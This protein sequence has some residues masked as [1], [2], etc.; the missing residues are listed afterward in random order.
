MNKTLIAA[1]VALS[2]I[3]SAQAAPT[4][5]DF[6]SVTA[7][8]KANGFS[9]PG[10]PG[11]TFTDSSGGDLEVGNYGNQGIGKSLLIGN[12]D[13]SALSIGFATQVNSLSLAFGNDDRSY[14]GQ[15]VFAYLQLFSASTMIA[16]VLMAS[17][18][19]DI[20]N[21]TISYTGQLFDRA[22]FTYTNANRGALNLIEVVD[23]I[24]FDRTNAVPEPASMALLGLGFAGLACLR[25]RKA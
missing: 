9:V 17:N 22:V 16:D 23:N 14:I 3:A 13:A 25:R 21:Q 15:S 2:A 24:T 4:T 6:E 5:I 12:D 8:T 19:D 11:V 18:N 20:M 7:G 1:A 10:Q